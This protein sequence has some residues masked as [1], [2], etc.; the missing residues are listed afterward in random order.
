MC[1]QCARGG[2]A[3][4]FR[5]RGEPTD[6]VLASAWS[7]AP[8]TRTILNYGLRLTPQTPLKGGFLALCF[9]SQLC[10]KVRFTATRTEM[11]DC[12]VVGPRGLCRP[13]D[14]KQAR[15]PNEQLASR[16]LSGLLESRAKQGDFSEEVVF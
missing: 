13:L 9:P 14:E 15:V 12:R 3:F 2:C 11:E 8:T 10:K 5:K 1:R 4:Y 7:P 16:T 6:R